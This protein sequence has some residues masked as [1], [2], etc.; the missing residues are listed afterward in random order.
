MSLGVK[1]STGPSEGSYSAGLDNKGVPRFGAVCFCARAHFTLQ[2]N[3][4]N[5]QAV[6]IDGER[7]RG[8]NVLY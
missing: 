5:M 7:V 4:Q 8:V 1:L 2:E 6:Q 3:T